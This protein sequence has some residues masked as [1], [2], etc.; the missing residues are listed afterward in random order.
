MTSSLVAENL[1]LK[2]GGQDIFHIEKLALHGGE[3]LALVIVVFFRICPVRDP[4]H[5][6]K[7][8][9]GPGPSGI[10]VNKGAPGRT[11]ALTQNQQSPKYADDEDCS[12]LIARP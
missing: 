11:I 3:V 6:K 9:R 7:R 8:S 4:V 2:R 10:S 5:Q 12:L 1:N